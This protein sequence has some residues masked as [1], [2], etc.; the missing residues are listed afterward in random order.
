MW[1]LRL[2][3]FNL[4]K[5]ERLVNDGLLRELKVGYL[6]VCESYLEGNMTTRS[7]LAKGERAKAPLELLH[8]DACRLLSSQTRGGC[9]CFIICM[10]DYSIYEYT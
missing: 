7:F 10:D 1:Y 4:N 3:H 2:G 6:F 8:S 5:I 9:E